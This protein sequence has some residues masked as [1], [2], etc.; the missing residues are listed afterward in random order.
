MYR[1]I[2]QYFFGL[3]LVFL[4]MPAS[5]QRDTL[6]KRVDCDKSR[7]EKI[8]EAETGKEAHG[9]KQELYL[10]YL[11]PQELPSWFFIPSEYSTTPFYAIGI[12]EPGMDSVKASKL[13]VLRA[14]S[15][16]VLSMNTQ[17][18]NISDHFQIVRESETAM[19]KKSQYL[20]FSRFYTKSLV[21][22]GSF[23]VNEVFYTKY[24]EAIALISYTSA[25]KGDDTLS[26]N[27]EIMHLSKENSHALENTVLCRLDIEYSPNDTTDTNAA[28][29]NFL[30]RRHGERFNISSV[31]NSDS[32]RFPFHPFR[33]SHPMETATDSSFH[34]QSSPLK[35]GLWNAYISLIFSKISYYNRNLESRVKTSYDNYNLKNQG[36][37]RTVSTNLLKFEIDSLAVENNE[38]FLK[39]E[40]TPY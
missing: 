19:E 5:A 16:A 40:I 30:L 22:S 9:D 1:L 29:S 7:Y 32:L 14:A 33:Y 28:K 15:L 27:G 26:V 13:A 34:M 25:Q 8:M 23:E 37:I 21:N 11:F 6:R 39:I 38:L 10:Y 31:Y 24:G 3:W 18:D 2:L 35:F 20:D 36:L 12:S 17:I 4:V